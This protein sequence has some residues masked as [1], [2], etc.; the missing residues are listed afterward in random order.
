MGKTP[1]ARVGLALCFPPMDPSIF[2]MTALA[3]AL[4]RGDF[5]AEMFARFVLTRCERHRDLHALIAQD[6]GQLVA[7]A[8][9]VDR[10]RAAGAALGALHGV[11]VL[12]KDNIDA[13]GYATTAGTPGLAG[14]FPDRNAPVVQ[15]LLDAGALVA[16][17]ANLHELAVGATSRNEHFGQVVN[18][19]NRNVIAGGSSGGSAVAVAARMVPGAIGTDT[20]GSVRGPCSLNGIA[21]FRPSFRRYPYGGIIPST[22][23]RDS[24]GGMAT[25]VA[26]LALLD[27]VLAGEPVQS[28]AATDL[29]GVRLGR[30]GGEFIAGVDARTARVM[31]E[32]VARLRDAG[33]TIVAVELPG[34]HALARRT[35]W[36]IS[37]YEAV[38]EI[39]AALAGRSPA[40]SVDAIVSRIASPSVRERFNPQPGKLAKLEGPYRE[41]LEV[42]RPK[43]RQQLVGCFHDH[44]LDALVYPTTPFPAVD[45]PDEMAS[46]LVNGEP[47]SFGHIIH[48]SVYQSAAGIPSLT[49]PAGLTS[50]G[51][52]VGLGLDGPEGSD[53][54]LLAIGLAFEVLRDPFPLPPVAASESWLA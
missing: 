34:L 27:A 31:D 5:S 41:A 38:A 14:V 53:R 42:L 21:G 20:N 37:A 25:T 45:V 50:D 23:T 8:R 6:A 30:P 35:A 33:A 36:P 24:V 2:S 26:D 54:H 48:N 29:R 7:A 16:G 12:V 4:A 13:V 15:R 18:P 19:W 28:L 39:D 40:V 32:A 46:V 1:L 3:R 22:S 10:R 47:V 51:L 49:V 44:R 9:A 17:K 52:P 43:L 11:P